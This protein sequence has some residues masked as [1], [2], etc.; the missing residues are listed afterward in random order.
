MFRTSDVSKFVSAFAE[1]GKPETKTFTEDQVKASIGEVEKKFK[2]ERTQLLQKLQMLETTAKLT[3]EEREEMGKTVEDLRKKV[4]TAEELA[5]QEV[6]KQS[7][8]FKKQLEGTISERDSWRS[9][10]S[11]EKITRAIMDA[12]V[13]HEAFNPRQIVALVRNDAFLEEVKGEDGQITE[14]RPMV[15]IRTVDKSKKPVEL[16]LSPEQAIEQ[17]KQD[18]SYF[19]LFKGTMKDGLGSNNGGKGTKM[20][21][22]EAAK[23]GPE[24]FRK[25]IAENPQEA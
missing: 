23:A 14:H 3:K 7:D 16:V 24:V 15:K 8:T 10:F 22:A 6:K 4:F 21:L 18:Q 11:E 2:E 17:L 1:E 19:N 13:T 12:A 20:T 9:K 5:S 25:F